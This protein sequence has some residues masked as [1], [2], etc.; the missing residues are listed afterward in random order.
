MCFMYGDATLA[1][2]YGLFGHLGFTDARQVVASGLC[3]PHLRSCLG[4]RYGKQRSLGV[5][6]RTLEAQPPALP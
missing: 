1:D 3:L 5:T 2:T 4:G 6:R